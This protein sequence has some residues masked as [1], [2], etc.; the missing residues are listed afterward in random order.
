MLLATSF[1]FSNTYATLD[2]LKQEI[3][4]LVFPSSFFLQTHAPHYTISRPQGPACH[5]D[6][7]SDEQIDALTPPEKAAR[8]RHNFIYDSTG[9][10]KYPVQDN[11][12]KYQLKDMK[13]DSKYKKFRGSC[14]I[15]LI[16]DD[17]FHV[18]H[19][20]VKMEFLPLLAPAK[21]ADL[22]VELLVNLMNPSYDFA[23][24]KGIFE[25]REMACTKWQKIAGKGAEFLWEIDEEGWVTE[26]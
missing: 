9:T 14:F 17:F 13:T 1:I 6:S 26:D 21:A 8:I 5:P 22:E 11:H 20:V 2:F 4:P 3:D 10:R 18:N 19:L 7:Y 24:E 25:G 16:A 23:A 12:F 15:T